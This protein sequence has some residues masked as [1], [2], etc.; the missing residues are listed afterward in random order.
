M[1][2]VSQNLTNYMSF[3]DSAVVRINLA[4]VED[5]SLLQEHIRQ[6]SNNIYLDLPVGRTKPPNNSYTI[7][8]LN[9]IIV[10]NRNIK[11][12]AISNV[13]KKEH[14]GNFI[15]TF[16]DT[17]TIVPKIETKK[18]VDNIE[19]ICS[20]LPDNKYIMLDHDDLFS[21][22][23]KLEIMP[24]EFITYIQR[25]SSYC[26][27]NSINLLKTRGVVFSDEDRYNFNE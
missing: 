8:D 17:V 16:N 11:F 2:L 18:G 13:E 1:L 15:E 6:I 12:L 19:D 9:E 10:E 5:L 7:K 14:I 27:E 23:I 26:S 21:D 25:L 20:I 24:S 22:L 3:P 4:W